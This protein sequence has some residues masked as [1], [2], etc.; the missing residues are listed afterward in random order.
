MQLPSVT[1]DSFL[2]LAESLAD[3]Y[4]A[5]LYFFT[6]AE[7]LCDR[8][9]IGLRPEKEMI[10]K[11]KTTRA[12][13][14]SFAFLDSCPTFGY[15]SYQYGM[16]QRA[17]AT[18]HRSD[19]SLGHLK[20]Y[21]V[22][23]IWHA[24]SGQ[25]DIQ[26][27]S[28]VAAIDF[29]IIEILNV[30]KDRQMINANVLTTPK[31]AASQT[32]NRHDY[33]RRVGQVIDYIINGYSYQLN[34]SIKYTLPCPR[35]TGGGLFTDFYRRYPA[36]YY[37][38]FHSGDY[39]IISTSPERFLRVANSQVLSQPIK[40]TLAFGQY[41]PALITKLTDSPKESSELSMIVDMMRNDISL[42]CRYGSVRVENHKSTFV[43][44]N[45]L[46]MYSDVRGELRDDRN[47]VDLLI[48]A[49]PGA[50]V[51]GCP[52]RK[53]MELIDLL[54][55]HARDVYCGSLFMI[56]SPRDLESSVAIRTGYID[57]KSSLLSFFSG[58]GIVIDSDPE[59][60]Y[61]ETMAKAGKFLGTCGRLI[62]EL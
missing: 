12:D 21:S 62:G 41:D 54:E 35:A 2:R 46:Q 39:E 45:L 48:D 47:V 52:K 50:S 28:N 16:I 23:V 26:K 1:I 6:G 44:D 37:A 40:G 19:F 27:S 43:V 58:S 18:R 60:E 22:L 24:D 7:D 42:N 4:D 34:L 55:P 8:Y 36:S 3:R 17:V 49:F 14:A 56:K 32:L 11:A 59:K 61:A 57:R 53:A 20:K 10:V 9:L 38:Y 31:N 51:T 33:T 25:L 29:P 15:L 30:E 5:D 13:I